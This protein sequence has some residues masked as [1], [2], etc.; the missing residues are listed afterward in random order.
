MLFLCCEAFILF[1]NSVNFDM[2]IG[3]YLVNLLLFVL[4]KNK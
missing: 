4:K 3:S 1:K 2:L